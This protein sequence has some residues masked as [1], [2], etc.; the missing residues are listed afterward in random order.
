MLAVCCVREFECM[1]SV[2]REFR[3]IRLWT[4]LWGVIVWAV[5]DM[6]TVQQSPEDL[7]HD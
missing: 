6:W 2:K 5:S 3:A 4:L 1:T 7:E